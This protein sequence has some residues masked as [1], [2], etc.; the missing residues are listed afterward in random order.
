LDLYPNDPLFLNQWELTKIW[1]PQTRLLITGINP[2]MIAIVG[3]G[4]DAGHPDLAG[5]VLAEYYFVKNGKRAAGDNG[6]GIRVAGNA[7]ATSN[8]GQG[9]ASVAW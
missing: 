6:H 4:V 7:A 3:T 8:N 5:K 1:D 9:V 2:L